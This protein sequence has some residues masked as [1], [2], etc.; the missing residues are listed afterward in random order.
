MV[1]FLIKNLNMWNRITLAQNITT[2][3]ENMLKLNI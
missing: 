2:Q 3:R 1:D